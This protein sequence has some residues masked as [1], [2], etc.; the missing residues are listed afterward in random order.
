MARRQIDLLTT[1]DLVVLSYL[2]QKPM[3]GYELNY[4]LEENEVKDW[5]GISRPQVYYSLNKLRKAKLIKPASD[6]DDPAGPERQVFGVTS[7]GSS[8]LSE[9]LCREK[10][11]TQRPPAPFLTWMALSGHAKPETIRNLISKRRTFLKDELERETLT[12][13]SFEKE[14]GKLVEIGKLMVGLTIQHFKEELSWLNR[15]EK[16]LLGK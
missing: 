14:S 13:K 9:A 2:S 15:V 4:K 3:H 12:M 11:A 10:W 16:V 6:E 5:A 8:A 1:P 7:Q